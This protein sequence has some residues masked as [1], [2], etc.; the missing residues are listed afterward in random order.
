MTMQVTLGPVALVGI[1]VLLGLGCAAWLRELRS[2][3]VAESKGRARRCGA[4]GRR[5]SRDGARG[6]NA[7]LEE[8]SPLSPIH[9]H[10]SPALKSTQGEM[11]FQ[12]TATRETLNRRLC[13]GV[14]LAMLLV[15]LVV[16]AL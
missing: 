11:D 6:Y 4:R 10:Q 5:T 16:C 8:D 9:S 13:A 14:L 12:E 15:F 3:P 1:C 2:Q 7:T